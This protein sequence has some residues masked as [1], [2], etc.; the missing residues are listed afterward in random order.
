MISVADRKLLREFIEIENKLNLPITAIH[1]IFQL[2]EN[3]APLFI[4]LLIM[5]LLV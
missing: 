4:N 2:Q 1:R 3:F 5:G